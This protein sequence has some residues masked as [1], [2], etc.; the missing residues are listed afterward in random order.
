MIDIFLP[1]ADGSDRAGNERED[2]IPAL[3]RPKDGGHANGEKEGKP[4]RA[5]GLVL[6][7]KAVEDDAPRPGNERNAHCR[8][9][10]HQSPMR[11]PKD[12]GDQLDGQHARFGALLR[13]E[14]GDSHGSEADDLR[15][16]IRRSH[17]L[18]PPFIKILPSLRGRQ[19]YTTF[20]ALWQDLLR[21]YA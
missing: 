19:Y 14:K 6:L 2:G 1:V 11:H 20:A 16:H 8:D 3:P 12:V 5:A 15:D 13:H 17:S 21:I 18:P 9:R 10:A 4:A 7:F